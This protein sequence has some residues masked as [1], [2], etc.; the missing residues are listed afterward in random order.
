MERHDLERIRR[1]LA[2]SP[3]VPTSMA[4]ELVCGL[5]EILKDRQAIERLAD[6]LERVAAE[7]RRLVA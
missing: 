5:E 3:S 4:Q 2:M 7:I 6:E 1:S